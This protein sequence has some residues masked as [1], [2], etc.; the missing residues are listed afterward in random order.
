M[1]LWNFL[2]HPNVLPCF[3]FS[4]EFG[5][6]PA[7]VSP[8][9]RSGDLESYMKNCHHV[10]RASIAIDMTFG[11]SYLHSMGVIHGNI[12]TTNVLIGLKGEALICDF[13]VSR[14]I[15]C[16][17]FNTSLAGTLPFMAPELFPDEDN[18]VPPSH[19]KET[20]VWA[21]GL[22]LLQVLTGK[23][24]NPKIRPYGPSPL[25]KRGYY[26]PISDDLWTL[27]KTCCELD[28]SKRPTMQMVMQML[29]SLDVS[30]RAPT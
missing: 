5:R 19:T 21:C 17:S 26:S 18:D 25:P 15:G 3:G 11:L 6:F 14:V 12:K 27:A 1:N 24:P 22:V 9:C 7:L 8:F 4:L 29:P 20:D 23:Q 30:S 16:R 28:H 13:G 2:N 10:D